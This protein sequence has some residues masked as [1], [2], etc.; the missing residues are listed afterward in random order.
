MVK[1][2]ITAFDSFKTP[3]P[4]CIPVVVLKSSVVEVEVL[5]Y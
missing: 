4:A 2:T 3:V 5:K 1:S